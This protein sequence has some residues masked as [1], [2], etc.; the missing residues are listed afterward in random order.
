LLTLE[1]EVTVLG[2]FND[3]SKNTTFMM[4]FEMFCLNMMFPDTEIY[5]NVGPFL[6]LNS[7]SK[8]RKGPH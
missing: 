6:P 8:R 2:L 7:N 5:S 4:L 1:R 3:N